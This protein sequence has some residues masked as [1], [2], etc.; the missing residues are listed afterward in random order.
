MRKKDRKAGRQTDRQTLRKKERQAG[1]HDACIETY[2]QAKTDRQKERK[3][4]K[5]EIDHRTQEFTI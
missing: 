5:E 2:R 3:K 4:D 1:R